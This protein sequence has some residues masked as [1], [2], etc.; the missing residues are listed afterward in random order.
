MAFRYGDYPLWKD[1]ELWC[2]LF[3][4]LVELG[5]KTQKL[6]ETKHGLLNFVVGGVQKVMRGMDGFEN[7]EKEVNSKE[8]S[9]GQNAVCDSHVPEEY[10][11]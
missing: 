6:K 7:I 9:E 11:D 8:T 1:I 2:S 4:R 5:I 3:D 10:E